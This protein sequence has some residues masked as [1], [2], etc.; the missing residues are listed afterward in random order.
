VAQP[1]GDVR[2]LSSWAAPWRQPDRHHAHAVRDECQAR[3]AFEAGGALALPPGHPLDPGNSSHT[4]A[5]KA[6]ETTARSLSIE[7]GRGRADGILFLAD[8]IFFI[9]LRRVADLVAA[10][11]LPAVS[12][13]VEFPRLGGLM[14]Y[15]PSLPEEFRLPILGLTIPQSLLIRA[16]EVMQ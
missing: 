13:F 5:L 4:T 10:A 2:G 16:D 6:A 9:G 12:N 3:R 11:R 7:T 14:G 8:P 15:A 1:V